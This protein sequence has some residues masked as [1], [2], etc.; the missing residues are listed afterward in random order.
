[1]KVCVVN[2]QDLA[3]MANQWLVMNSGLSA[4]FNGDRTVN[5]ADFNI[6]ANYWMD[7]CPDGWTLN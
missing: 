3:T 1:V 5:F 7:Y 2:Y 4:N 6:L